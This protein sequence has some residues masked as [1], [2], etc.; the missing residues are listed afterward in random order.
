MS[1]AMPAYY[2]IYR[3]GVSI[4]VTISLDGISGFLHGKV[5]NVDYQ[6]AR[7]GE[8]MRRRVWALTKD[9]HGPDRP[10]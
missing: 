5:Q 10:V 9:I 6:K 8:S 2:T 1:E 3:L 4:D 7:G